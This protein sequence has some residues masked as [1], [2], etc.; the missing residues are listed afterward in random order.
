LLFVTVTLPDVAPL[1]VGAYCTLSVALC[2]GAIVNGVAILLTVMSV[3]LLTTCVSVTLLFP[4][5][6]ICRF[7][8]AAL[9]TF[10]LPKLKLAGVSEIVL[11]AAVP[12]PLNATVAG[13]FGELLTIDTVPLA[14]PAACGAYCTLM[15]PLCPGVSVIG[16]AIPLTLNPVPVT[17]AC[18]I[19]TFAVPVFFN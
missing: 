9:P 13:E 2:D 5:F 4:V 15:F 8:V 17:A 14:L 1:V 19:V 18:D 10:T 16:R 7:C 11:V 3:P 6:E 12:V